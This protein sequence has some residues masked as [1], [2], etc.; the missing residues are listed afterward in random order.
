MT[1]V[2]SILKEYNE[3]KETEQVWLSIKEYL[4][5]C[6]P[7]GG[8][9]ST[10]LLDGA[11]VPTDVIIGVLADIDSMCLG[12]VQ[13]RVRKIETTKVKDAKEDKADKAGK[14]KERKRASKKS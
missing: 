9:S 8:V 3:L 7:E 4:E 11:S 13:D 10:I 2:K 6:L 12:P 1:T 5:R 14:T